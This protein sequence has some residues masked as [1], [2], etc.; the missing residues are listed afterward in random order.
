[1]KN[2]LT[3]LFLIAPLMACAPSNETVS[4]RP[5]EQAFIDCGVTESESAR[6]MALSQKDFDQDMEGGWRVIANQENCKSVA[7][8]LIE[9]YI[10]FHNIEPGSGTHILYWH[11]GQMHAYTGDKARDRL[12][13]THL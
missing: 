13:E 10:A 11:A 7:G 3:T 8:Y 9:D 12:Y 1:M 6:L 4:Q 2:L 5:D